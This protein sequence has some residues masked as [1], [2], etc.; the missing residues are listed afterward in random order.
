MGHEKFRYDGKRAVVLGGASGMGRATA[1]LLVELGAEV[2][3]LDVRA[4]DFEVT[5]SIQMDLRDRSSI[6][7]ALA[8]LP[9]PVHAFFS[10]SGIW[11]DGGRGVDLMLV[12]FIGQ[13]HAIEEAIRLGILGDGSAVAMISSEGGN[14]WAENLATVTDFLATPDF[15]SARAWVEANP[16][17]DSYTFSKQAMD[18]YVKLRAQP[19]SLRGIRINATA[20][21]PTMT[22]LMRAHDNWLLAETTFRGLMGD[23]AGATPEEQAYPLVFLNSEAA[24]FVSGA[25]LH[26]DFGYSAGGMMGVIPVKSTPPL[27]EAPGI[28]SD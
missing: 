15:D 8:R 20:P 13:R 17:S 3:V 22:P 9:R 16:D 19:L 18:A 4:V 2:H 12:N 10:C 7:A 27:A 25:I 23:R 24:A 21:G 14:R 1:E 6:D 26:V 28:R 11:G 5:G